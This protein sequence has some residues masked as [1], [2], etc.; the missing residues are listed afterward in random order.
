MR[1]AA[2]CTF[3]Q[4]WP[5]ASAWSSRTA[6]VAYKCTD[7]YYPEHERTLLWSDPRLAIQWPLE[8]PIL[9]EKDR[10]GLTLDEAP[11]FEQPFELPQ[12]GPPV[13][14]TPALE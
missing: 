10:A 3:R 6:Q 5:T 8:D 13:R 14:L 11:C 9:S 12:P 4:G 2:S 1:T 7:Y